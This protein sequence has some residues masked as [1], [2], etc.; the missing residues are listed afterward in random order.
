[1]QGNSVDRA[2][3]DRGIENTKKKEEIER[4]NRNE[5]TDDG[6]PIPV[7]PG[8]V[9]TPPKKMTSQMTWRWIAIVGVASQSWMRMCSIRRSSGRQRWLKVHSMAHHFVP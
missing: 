2:L 5:N 3:S 8:L 9:D 6:K 1:M 7:P 4:L